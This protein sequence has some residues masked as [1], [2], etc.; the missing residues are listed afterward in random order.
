M[1]REDYGR[2]RLAVLRKRAADGDPLAVNELTRR[3]AAPVEDITQLPDVALR[4]MVRAW[5][6]GRMP[7]DRAQSRARAHAAHAELVARYR[8]DMRMFE[9]HSG[10]PPHEVSVPPWEIP[11][12]PRVLS[13]QR[14]EGSTLY[15]SDRDIQR[16]QLDQGARAYWAQRGKQP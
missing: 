3:G 14:Q 12:P 7:E 2:M 6:T 5:N 4:Q 11:R 10:T 13:W 15:P 8:A 16:A 1:Q 9:R